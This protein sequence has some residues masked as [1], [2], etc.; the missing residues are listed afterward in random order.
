[1]LG[2]TSDSTCEALDSCND[3]FNG[4]PGS[5][6]DVDVEAGVT[7]RVVVGVYSVGGTQAPDPG[8]AEL[9]VIAL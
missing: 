1:V 4:G 8:P 7:Y 6:V 9:S 3:E 2:F 5:A